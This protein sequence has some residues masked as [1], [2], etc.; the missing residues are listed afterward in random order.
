M[1]ESTATLIDSAREVRNARDRLVNG[2]YPKV[3]EVVAA[4]LEVCERTP[5]RLTRLEDA[6]DNYLEDLALDG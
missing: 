2:L 4:A 6:L 5:G 3:R 1:A